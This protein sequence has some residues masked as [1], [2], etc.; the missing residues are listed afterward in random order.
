MEQFVSPLINPQPNLVA[1]PEM[2]R[3]DDPYA[4]ITQL[5]PLHANNFYY[6][7]QKIKNNWITERDIEIA[8]FVLVHRWVVLDQIKRLFFPPSDEYYRVRHRMTR[9][10]KFGILRRINWTS[11]SGPDR[12][13]PSIY[14]LGD[15]GADI[16][17]LRLGMFIGNR[18]PRQ[19][20]PATMLF[21]FRYV[22]TNELYI[23]LREAFDMVYFEFHPN[24]HWKEE[25]TIP[26]AKYI[27]RNPKG[28]EMPFYLCCYR[29]DEKWVKTIRFQ[30]LFFKQYKANVDPDAIMVVLVSTDEKALLASKIAEQ[31]G[32]SS[33]TWYVT[34]KDLL[35]NNVNLSQGF[36]FFNNGKK[37]HYD[38]R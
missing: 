4:F 25:K 10:L 21:R 36:F 9:L 18:D 8:K 34:D 7:E 13:R 20:K 6:I 16:L 2:P 27:L 17:K 30:S 14:E 33:F 11:Y 29:E 23:K 31:E 26:T 35:F 22:I 32:T 12:N 1:V 28:R 15:S 24:L 38:L 37:T 19:A 3:W 5:S